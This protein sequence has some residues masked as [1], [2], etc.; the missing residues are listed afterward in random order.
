M[1]ILKELHSELAQ[2]E[3]TSRDR[4]VASRA[5][6]AGMS[7]KQSISGPSIGHFV[8]DI[9]L[10]VNVS[11]FLSICLATKRGRRGHGWLLR[12]GPVQALVLEARGL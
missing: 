5:P 1:C 11:F 8:F 3:V 12:Q 6:A 4:Q 7:Q 2:N 10:C 9:I